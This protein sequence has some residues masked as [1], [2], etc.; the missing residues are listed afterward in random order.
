MSFSQVL[1]QGKVIDEDGAP[2]PFATVVVEG[3]TTGT[4][5]D[6]EG[7]FNIRAI[8][9]Q[10]LVVQFVGYRTEIV[11]VTDLNEIIIVTLQIEVLQIE[12]VVVVGYGVQKK[13]SVVGAIGTTSGDVIVEQGNV[14]NLK[15]ALTG[16]IPGVSVLSSSGM[17]GGYYDADT[18]FHQPTEI[19]IRGKATWNDASPLIL[20][21]GVERAIEDVDANEVESV[22]VLKDASATAVFGMKGGNGVILINTKRG[23]EGKARFNIEAQTSFETPSKIIEVVDVPEAAIARNIGLNRIRRFGNEVWD[24][25]YQAD[26]EIEYFRTGEYPYVYQ[27]L[28]WMD[29]MLKDFTTSYRLNTSVR[30]GTKTTKYFA[31]ASYNHEGDLFDG[32]DVGQGYVPSYSYDRFTIRSNFDFDITETTKL[33]ANISGMLGNQI[34]PAGSGGEIQFGI[35]NQASG[36]VPIMVYE[37]GI[38]GADQ[39]RFKADN[40]YAR[41]NYTGIES[42][43]RTTVNMDY[44]LDQNLDFITKG[45]LL[46]G[47]LAYD[48][49]FNND[50]RGVGDGGMTSKTIDKEFYLNGGY[51]DKE[52]ET[53]MLD[54]QPANM[55]EWTLYV[56]EVS[57]YQGFGFV[58]EPNTYSAEDN[59]LNSAYRSLYYQLQLRYNRSFGAHGVTGMSMFSRFKSERGGNW[60]QKREDWVGRLTYDYDLRYFLEMNG[61]YNGSEKFGPEYRFDFFPSIAVGWMVSNENFFKNFNWLDKFKIRYSYG[62]VGNDRVNTGTQWPYLT[63]WGTYDLA[64]EESAYYG[65]PYPY[66]EYSLY[67]EG[68][69]GN[70]ALRWEKARK[71]N[72]G[73]EFAAFKNMIS[74][75][76]DLFNEDRYD[77]LLAASQRTETVPP[78]FGKDAPAANTGEA[79][80]KGA[81]LE[82]IFRSSIRNEFYYS[83]SGNWSV[84]RSEVIF[85]ESPDLMP[86]HQKPEGKPIGQTFSSQ[87]T[88][89]YESWDDLF[90]ATGPYNEADAASL[91]PGDLIML[92]YNA[93]GSY[94]GTYDGAPYEYPTYPQNNY[95][96]ALEANYKSIRFTVRFVGAYNTTRNI[97]THLFYE[98]NLYV[99]VHLLADT[100]TPEYGNENPSYPA[101]ALDDKFYTPEGSYNQ[102]DGSF[103]RLQSIQLSYALPENFSSKLRLSGIRFYV[104]GRNLYVW[105]KMPNDGVG[106]DHGGK[107]YPTKIQLNFGLNINL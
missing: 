68:N 11:E 91:L 65:Y 31:S 33:S 13:E 107:N 46:S 92:D 4:T 30:G 3:T 10:R 88:G 53:Y 81:E 99:P 58:R 70:Q 66:K 76:A 42:N 8:E 43:L 34:S 77:M 95:G 29:V 69:P 20:V 101:L 32:V 25:L 22:S 23:R 83:I 89:F 14:T 38:P 1:I 6:I 49:T 64:I 18:K 72:L 24:E 74:F 28:D 62:L 47:M 97:S 71:Q 104:N 84:A 52:T 9:G 12:D 21:D 73:F 96:I 45:L 59:S 94:R 93:D 51:Y 44:K 57:P 78:I 7:V 103:F 50:G 19:L 98:D 85:K 16:L 40:P 63:T 60:P 79:K 54:G 55:D 102:F 27:N 75:T 26:Q 35:F 61:A 56:E 5:T 39:R 2:V 105:T 86:E 80:S 36:N 82:L 87:S 41:F 90:C 67:L 37:D 106:A 15:E 17:P 48:N 100:W